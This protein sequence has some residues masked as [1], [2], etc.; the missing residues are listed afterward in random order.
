[1]MKI[2]RFQNVTERLLLGILKEA[3]FTSWN[4]GAFLGK[5]RSAFH[6]TSLFAELRL[7]GSMKPEYL[8][9]G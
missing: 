8:I 6:R 2:T 5:D 7:R 3:M 4:D 1:M 9:I